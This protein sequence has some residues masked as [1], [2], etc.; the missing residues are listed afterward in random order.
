MNRFLG[1]LLAVFALALS[2]CASP[3][4]AAGNRLKLVVFKQGATASLATEVTPGAGGA[5]AA[6]DITT[7]PEAF[8]AVNGGTT[9][10]ITTANFVPYQTSNGTTRVKIGAYHEPTALEYAAGHAD[11]MEK[12]GMACDGGS[13]AYATERTGSHGEFEFDVLPAGADRLVEC[14]WAAFATTGIPRTGTT[15]F[16]SNAGGTL[17]AH[18]LIVDDDGSNVAGCGEGGAAPAC[19]TL[20]YARNQMSAWGA[21]HGWSA[22]GSGTV[23][24]GTLCLMPGTYRWGNTTELTTYETGNQYLTIKPCPGVTRAQVVINGHT[25]K[26]QN[27]YDFN[28]GGVGDGSGTNACGADT[29]SSTPS[30]MRTRRVHLQNVTTNCLVIW[31]L[32]TWTGGIN[33]LEDIDAIA[34]YPLLANPNVL[35]MVAGGTGASSYFTRVTARGIDDYS[36]WA[37]TYQRAALVQDSTATGTYAD[38]L[39]GAYNVYG[40][41]SRNLDGQLGAHPD[42]WQWPN[43]ESAAYSVM[44]DI[45]GTDNLNAQLIFGGTAGQTQY[46][47]AFVGWNID[48]QTNLRFPPN[49]SNL[50]YVGGAWNHVF[51]L[52]NTFGNGGKLGPNVT[53]TTE[54]HFVD[55]TCVGDTTLGWANGGGMTFRG[56]TCTN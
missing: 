17:P 46:E 50:F 53:G 24:G 56:G 34:P 10:V 52:D 29:V 13:I 38:E 25:D 14:R 20:W 23:G 8:T 44:V 21:S 37:Q 36:G 49:T 30:G 22:A 12:V 27:F 54:V 26:S 45:T 39:F 33:W 6:W 41:T 42:L 3:A 40:F 11:N 4:D 15:Y 47:A 43:G 9:S 48:N 31:N 7:F 28:A 51:F 35:F 16:N 32:A 19:Q 55:N 5:W 18:T 1:S 2:A